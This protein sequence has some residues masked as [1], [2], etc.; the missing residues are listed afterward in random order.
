MSRR[1]SALALSLIIVSMTLS[2]CISSDENS[3]K[4]Y[5]DDDSELNLLE[6][7]F[8]GDLDGDGELDCP[9]SGYIPDTTPWWCNSSGIGGHPVSYTHLTLPTNREV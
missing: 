7:D 4:K 3:E 8:C 6:A 1:F 2:G 9:L 5:I